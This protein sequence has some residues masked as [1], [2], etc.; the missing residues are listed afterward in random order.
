M[1]ET[2]IKLTCKVCNATGEF[3]SN[4]K[5]SKAGW[6]G[7]SYAK[8]C[9][10]C[11]PEA[12]KAAEAKAEE[13][14]AASARREA[15]LEDAWFKAIQAWPGTRRMA[16]WMEGRIKKAEIPYR[17]HEAATGSIYFYLGDD[18][19][20]LRVSN[21]E[22]AEGG[23]YRGQDELGDQHYDEAHGD[24]NPFNQSQWREVVRTAIEAAE[25]GNDN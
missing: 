24:V 7:P 21:H 10:Q 11:A 20:K 12:R 1:T 22:A 18:D 23:G 5:A 8:S 14:R 9:P 13:D 3:G 17:R 2:V 16:R 25:G 19:V 4:R 15:E 6:F